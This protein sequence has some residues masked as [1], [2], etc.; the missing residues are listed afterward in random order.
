MVTKQ[1]TNKGL[2]GVAVANYI[3]AQWSAAWFKTFITQYL[4]N[5]DIRNAVPGVGV[6]ISGNIATPATISLTQLTS[7]GLS[8]IGNPTGS[9]AS[10]ISITATG[11]G[12]VLVSSDGELL[13]DTLELANNIGLGPSFTVAGLTTGSILQALG[14]TTAAFSEFIVPTS[15]AVGD[16][17]YGSAINTISAL[18]AGTDTYVL[19][20]SAGVPTW[21]ASGGGGGGI[22][23]V[24]GTADQIDVSTV[25]TTATVSIDSAYAGQTSITTLGTVATGTWEGTAIAVAYGGVPS[26]SGITSGYILEND[27]GTPTWAAAPSGAV[28]ANPSATIGLSVIDGSATTFMRS[29]GAPPLS[30]AIAPTWTGVHTFSGSGNGNA[31]VLSGIQPWINAS[32][33]DGLTI[34][35]TAA[36]TLAMGGNFTIDQSGDSIWQMI[37]GAVTQQASAG[38]VSYTLYGASNEWT[39]YVIGGSTTNES[40]GQQIQAGTSSSD[41]PLNIINYANTHTLLALYGDGGMVM[42]GATGGDKGN[43]TI[44][45]SGGFYINGV[46]VSGGGGAVDVYYTSFAGGF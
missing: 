33:A 46:A 12:Q 28:G 5:A 7:P 39:H 8:V 27:A 21:A 16:L 17:W 10:D 43:G 14:P 45:V 37:S 1:T 44:N 24:D 6:S 32:G 19:T 3:P 13:F 35:A 29:D 2:S 34:S 23:A 26:T 40:F 15:V 38:Y 20:M 41:Q 18:A 22:T 4:Q 30:Q 42:Y 36:M 11:N 25:G 9:E 31:I